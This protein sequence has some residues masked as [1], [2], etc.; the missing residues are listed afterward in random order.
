MP[1]EDGHYQYGSPERVQNSAFSERAELYEDDDEMTDRAA[2]SGGWM[3]R[4]AAGGAKGE[5]RVNGERTSD[6]NTAE[7]R[8]S[9]G[10]NAAVRNASHDV[11]DDDNSATCCGAVFKGGTKFI[12][13]ILILVTVDIIWVASAAATKVR[14]LSSFIFV[15]L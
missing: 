4:E 1:H 11:L 10:R 13:G 15:H 5:S 12:V 8:G 9:R 2:S 3:A 7:V 14:V 6:S